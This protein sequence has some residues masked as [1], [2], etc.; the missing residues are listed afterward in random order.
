MIFVQALM[1][2]LLGND[3]SRQEAQSDFDD[4]KSLRH[5]KH[6]NKNECSGG[7]GNDWVE[8]ANISASG[9][10]YITSLKLKRNAVKGGGNTAVSPSQFYLNSLCC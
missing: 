10:H 9:A 8:D 6:S 3:T 2:V 4:T 1:E 5:R 7:R